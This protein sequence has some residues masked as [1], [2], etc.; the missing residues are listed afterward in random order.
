[1]PNHSTSSANMVPNGTAPED[2][3]LQRGGAWARCGEAVRAHG[4]E[5]RCV[6]SAQAGCVHACGRA[7]CGCGCAQARGERVRACGRAPPDEKV[8]DEE[9][10]EDDAGEEARREHNVLLPF[11]ALERLVQVGRRVARGHAHE[12]KE[13]QHRRHQAAAVGGREE[14]EH[15]K[16]CARRGGRARRHLSRRRRAISLAIS[17]AWQRLR[18][19]VCV[20][21]FACKP[22]RHR[23]RRAAAAASL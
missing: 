7:R 3:S 1:M 17:L 23:W 20:A 4:G 21:A 12:D 6:H 18:G 9:E 14:A 10:E 8:E 2:F 15:R 11:D 22:L 19:S 13:Q 16:D 5:R